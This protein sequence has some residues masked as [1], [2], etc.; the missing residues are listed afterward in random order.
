MATVLNTSE[1]RVLLRDV[2][3]KTYSRIVADRGNNASPRLTYDR[4]MLEIMGPS[5]RHE[6]LKE[7][8]RGLF[9]AL[10]EEMKLDFTPAGSTTFRRED[11][12]K[13]FEPDA[14]FYVRHAWTIRGKDE[15]DLNVDPP[16]DLVIEIDITRSSL[17][18]L[19]I[20]AAV[21]VPEVWR[22][23]NET[24]QIFTL[25]GAS[26]REQPL[27]LSLPTITSSVLTELV[28]AS[29]TMPRTEW[30]QKVRGIRR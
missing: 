28:R 27:S 11:L 23:Q 15:I 12:S 17:N 29:E 18:K 8:I 9:E 25:D 16:P 22:Y 19:E 20:Y 13:G 7:T 5:L 14:C 4:G 26:Y 10:A 30:I 21:Q 24:L 6:I 1:Q 2:S 3:W